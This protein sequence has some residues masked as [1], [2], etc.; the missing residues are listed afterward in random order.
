M[1]LH[2]VTNFGDQAVVLPVVA[3]T[4]LA[5]LILGWW[6][7]ALAWFVAVPATLGVVLL[8]KLSTIACQNL[9]PPIGLLSPSGHTASAAVVFGGVL[10][11]LLGRLPRGRVALAVLGAASV[12][13]AVGYTR[14]ALGVHTVA[15]VIAG[16]LIGVAGVAAF[17]ALAGRRPALPRAWIG[18]AATVVAVTVLF[19][20]RHVHAEKYIGQV[21]QQIWPLSVCAGRP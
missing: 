21:S 12:A 6:R 11:L 1:S 2:F 14:L 4:G 19:H 13:T 17:A 16:G 18:V 10:A 15:D 20:G 3:A 9:L 8:G 5:L 7:G